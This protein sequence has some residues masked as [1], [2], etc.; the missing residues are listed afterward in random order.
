MVPLVRGESNNRKRHFSLTIAEVV[1]SRVR[2]IETLGLST[3]AL[4]AW[5]GAFVGTS[6]A[7]EI[8]AASA[9]HGSRT[10][11]VRQV[12]D[13]KPAA[14]VPRR[15]RRAESR[16]AGELVSGES[17]L[18]ACPLFRRPLGVVLSGGTLRTL[19]RER[20]LGTLGGRR[21][22][23]LQRIHRLVVDTATVRRI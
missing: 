13:M 5:S 23:R 2:F 22:S 15:P 19:G 21:T 11:A 8:P 16:R 1:M 6:A 17:A 7:A 18:P 4:V 20:Q 10:V 12:A 3:L 9:A 14:L